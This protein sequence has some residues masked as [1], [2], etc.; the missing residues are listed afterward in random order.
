VLP[1]APRRALFALLSVSLILVAPVAA[2]TATA[3]SDPYVGTPEGFRLADPSLDPAPG[4]GPAPDTAGADRAPVLASEPPVSTSPVVVP[5][6]F[7]II[8][9]VSYVD[10]FL[11]CR[12]GCSRRHLGQDLM[13][14]KLQ[15]VL[16][17]FSGTISYL[18]RESYVGEGNYVSLRGD[19]GWTTNYIH[20]NNDSPGTDDGQGTASWFVMPGVREGARVF[21]GQQLG[22][23]GDSGNAEGTSPH[24]HFEL[25][26]GDAWSGTVYNPKLSLDRATRLARP[27]TSGPHPSGSLIRSTAGGPAMIVEAG[28]RRAV[29]DT[30]LSARGWRPEQV[31]A[32]TPSEV[33]SYP[34]GAAVPLRTGQVVRDTAYAWWVVASAGR[35]RISASDVEAMAL[36]AS[37]MPVVAADALAATPAA[38]AGTRKPG[39]VRE[40]GLIQESG[41]PRVYWIRHGSP[42]WVPDRTSFESFGLSFYDVAPVPAGTVARLGAGPSLGLQD[43]SVLATSAGAV[44]IVSGGTRRPVTDGRAYTAYGWRALPR[45]TVDAATLARQPAG[46]PLP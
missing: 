42:S 29:P 43:G 36:P 27:A 3:D 18:K 20:L 38:P 30:T 14:A 1:L 26:Q 46:A 5:M 9:S 35:L 11:A 6:T 22:W 24:I 10:S 28:R 4:T 2:S 33:A 44:S 39:R 23:V 19:N 37:R 8:G 13:A 17:T 45:W 34:A 41:S 31:I 25:R 21:P 15:P 16:A 40:G 12:S 7:P 32:V